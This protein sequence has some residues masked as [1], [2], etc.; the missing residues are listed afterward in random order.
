MFSV[1]TYLLKGNSV[2]ASELDLDHVHKGVILENIEHSFVDIRNE[3]EVKQYFQTYKKFF[4]EAILIKFND[5]IIFDFTYYDLTLWSSFASL[6]EDFL[7]T[8]SKTTEETVHYQAS[9]SL[10]NTDQDKVL[11][12]VVKMNKIQ[13]E[14]ELPKYTFLRALVDGG[15]HYYTTM[16]NYGYSH[17]TFTNMKSCYE[18]LAEKLDNLIK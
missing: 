11:F 15:L 13:L 1:H 18:E 14:I 4:R 12:S 9:I 16:C 7:A 8:D 10:E 3:L 2:I 6:I 17:I 5:D